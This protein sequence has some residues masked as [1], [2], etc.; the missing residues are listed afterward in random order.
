MT[1]T[2]RT[3]ERRSPTELKKH[4]KNIEIYGDAV[5][6]AFVEKCRKG[7]KLPVMIL[8][9]GTILSGH[10]RVQA[11]RILKVKEIDV[12]VI[13]DLTD[14]LDILEFVI[15]SNAQRVKTEEQV[16]RED[17]ELLS[18]ESERAARRKAAALKKG[19]NSAEIPVTEPGSG[20]GEATDIVGERTGVSGRTVRNRVAAV[21]AID[22]AAKAGD[23]ERAEGIRETLNT[24]GAKPAADKA[25][26]P[27]PPKDDPPKPEASEEVK[28][29]A[30][31]V[32]PK[33]LHDVFKA[34]PEFAAL[35][36]QLA[37]IYNDVVALADT[38]AGKWLSTNTIKVDIDNAKRHILGSA[39]H[40]VCPYCKAK[41]KSCDACKGIGW[42]HSGIYKQAPAEMKE[43]A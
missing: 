13:H 8:P 20:T 43:P 39:P 3:F 38:D 17:R 10:R 36:R 2:A 4:P 41:A 31:N 28:D 40:A 21:N 12:V 7:I 24:R 1:A 11:A 37:G 14:D 15:E 5:D 30:G 18:V 23:T 16:S 33:K 19:N 32:V 34:A 22:E 25:A 26:E 29:K 42:V 6:K 35:S 27:P 9:D